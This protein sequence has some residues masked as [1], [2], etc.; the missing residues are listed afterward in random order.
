[1]RP[2]PRPLPKPRDWAYLE[3]LFSRPGRFSQNPPV[4]LH[5]E[6]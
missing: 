6:E 4:R 1:M 5:I 3:E 2:L